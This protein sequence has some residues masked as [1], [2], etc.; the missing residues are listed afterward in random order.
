MKRYWWV[1][2]MVFLLVSGLVGVAVVMQPYVAPAVAEA[3]GGRA[4]FDTLAVLAGG[5]PARIDTLPTLEILNR[6]MGQT[7]VV[8]GEH[9]C[10]KGDVIYLADHRI[11]VHLDVTMTLT[12]SVTRRVWEERLPLAKDVVRGVAAHEF[13]HWL[14]HERPELFARFLALQ[15]DVLETQGFAAAQTAEALLAECFADAFA[16]AVAAR[17]P[18]AVSV[19]YTFCPAFTSRAQRA[20]L[21][22]GVAAGWKSFL[23]GER[24]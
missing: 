21:E 13:G 6:G 11:I 4:F 24:P 16:D 1:E 19:P 8:A 23:K 18:E 2:L 20:L 22:D 3:V 17:I 10:S 14:E 15:E 5:R 12:G 7:C 9:G